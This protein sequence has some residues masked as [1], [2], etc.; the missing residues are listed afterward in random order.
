MEIKI[1]DLEVGDKFINLGEDHT[2]LYKDSMCVLTD[3]D[4][5]DDSGHVRSICRDLSMLVNKIEPDKEPLCEFAFVYKDCD[6]WSLSARLRTESSIS[7]M[8]SVASYK[9]L[10]RFNPDTLEELK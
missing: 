6:Y 5:C 9:I 1:I 7:S 4:Y 8:G 2:V 10:R 3:V